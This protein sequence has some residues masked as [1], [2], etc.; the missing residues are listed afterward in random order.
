MT[1]RTQD[2]SIIIQ[3]VVKAAA[4]PHTVAPLVPSLDDDE[5]A[6]LM[7]VFLTGY[8]VGTYPRGDGILDDLVRPGTAEGDRLGLLA[9]AFAGLFVP[10]AAGLISQHPSRTRRSPAVGRFRCGPPEQLD[11]TARMTLL[12]H[13]TGRD[14]SWEGGFA[15]CWRS[16]V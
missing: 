15:A 8:R 6:K 11:Q 3:D 13:L 16:A 2:L 5:L 12:H 7:C 10:D 9:D 14:P 1:G 4:D